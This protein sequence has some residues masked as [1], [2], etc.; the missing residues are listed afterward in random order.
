MMIR[1]SAYF[2]KGN[3][4]HWTPYKKSKKLNFK[5]NLLLLFG[6]CFLSF[7]L[8]AES[9]ESKP[10][11]IKLTSINKKSAKP[12]ETIQL[13]GIWGKEQ[14]EKVPAINDGYLN[15]LIVLKWSNKKITAKIPEHLGPGIH[16]VGV[17]C[18]YR[19]GIT[20]YSTFWYDFEIIEND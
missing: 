6:L 12:G 16:K 20:I 15:E 1:K 2:R 5:I 9:D 13:S 8:N 17:Y 18:A 3:V 14:G 7:N 11:G 4:K 10:C 19:P